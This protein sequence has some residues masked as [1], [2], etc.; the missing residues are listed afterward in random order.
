[1]PEETLPRP[2]DAYRGHRLAPWLLGVALLF[3][4]LCSVNAIFIGRIVAGPGHGMPMSA[5]NDAGTRAVISLL[6]TWGLSQL[7]VCFVGLAVLVR[8][9]AL[10]PFMF[11]LLVVE[12]ASRQLVYFVAPAAATP[13]PPV[14]IVNLAILALAVVGLPLALRHRPASA[15]APVDRAI[16][17]ERV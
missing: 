15:P 12:H 1:M 13:F 10:L 11:G 16:S 7:M 5:L 17:S 6:A 4:T 2:L 9:R 3:K 14:A 8:Y